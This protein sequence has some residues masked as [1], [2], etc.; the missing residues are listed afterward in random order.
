A[1]MTLTLYEYTQDI[2]YLKKTFP[3]LLNYFFSWLSSTHDRDMDG[4]PEWDQ[5]IQTGY[6]EN[7]HFSSIYP[8]SMGIDISSVESPDLISYLYGE[9]QALCS[10]GERMGDDRTISLLDKISNKL[11]TMVD[12]SWSDQQASYQY[13]D[14]DSHISIPVE[15]LGRLNGSGIMEIHK[16]YQQAIRPFIHIKTKKEGTIPIQIYIHGTTPTGAHRIDH[17][18]SHLIHWHHDSGFV[19]SVL[20]YKSLEQIQVT[21]ITNEV[22]VIAQAGCQKFLD[23]T[24]LLPL[25][26]GIPSVEQAKI[27]IN[28]TLMNKKRFLS[29][30][31]IRSCIDNLEMSGLPDEFLSVSPLFM[32]L[33]IEG[34]VR[35]SEHKKA[36]ELF[37]RLMKAVVSSFNIDL[38]FHQFYHSE[39]GKPMGAVNTLSSLIPI[40][41][42]YKTLGVKIINSSKVEITGRNPFPWPVTIKYR[43]LTVVQQDKKTLVIFPDGQNATV[44]N[45]K[46]QIISL[47]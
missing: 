36:A 25:W 19:T 17:I 35:Y 7:P 20:I 1:R 43:G 46:S 16:E 44:E 12:N 15:F 14:R 26:V 9:C 6:E 3:K 42:F 28:L 38:K 22:E 45:N 18:P 37:T 32:G 31:G 24:L 10:I 30:Y 39:T 2:D 21:G 29:T 5:T 8:W 23:Q 34:L 33:F 4:I 27:F 47:A 41:S 40:G 13:R 11:K